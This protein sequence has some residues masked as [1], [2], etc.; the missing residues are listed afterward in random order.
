MEIQPSATSARR[1][2]S[3]VSIAFPVEVAGIDLSGNRFSART[4]TTSV[5][6]FGCCLPLPRHLRPDQRVRIRRIGTDETAVARVVGEMG[7][8]ADEHLYGVETLH[9]CEGLWGIRF[10]SAFNGQLLDNVHDGVYFVNRDRKIT[11]WNEAAER[12][13]G[14]AAGAAI[15]KHCFDNLLEHVDETGKSLCNDG[16]PL[17]KAM[18]DGQPQQS[19]IFLRHQDGHRVPV[20]VRVLPM[21]DTAGNIIGALEVFGDSK[22]KTNVERRVTELQ[23]M[24]FRDPLTGLPNRRYLGLKIEQGLQEH[25]LFGR[26]YGLLM[27]DLDGFKQVNDTHGHDTGDAL[28]KVVAETLVQGLRPIDIVGRWGGEEFLVLM[29]DVDAIG[30]GD[31]AERARVLIAKSSVSAGSSRVS[32]TASIGATVLNHSD[33]AEAAL[34]R[35]DELMYQSKRSGGDRTMAG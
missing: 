18:T 35:V 22:A 8:Q 26:L 32:V 4:K 14:Y 17:T 27:F 24:A 15:G 19:E 16:C 21:R 2:S 10:T 34:R 30:L 25:Q 33:S 11:Y 20:S 28:L 6:R 1:R 23:R 7:S 31:L 29:A 12:Q 13:A 3:R 9:S 5:S